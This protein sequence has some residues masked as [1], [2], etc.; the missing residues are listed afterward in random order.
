VSKLI[1]Q[2]V[3]LILP[4]RL[5]RVALTRIFGF[6]LD[7]TCRI[8]ISLVLPGHLVM[9]PHSRIGSLTMIKGLDHVQIDAW[10]FLGNLNWVTGLPATDRTFFVE[11]VGRRPSLHI[12]EHAAI[13]HRHMIDCNDRVEIGAFATF[14][15]WGSQILTHSIDIASSRQ[16]AESVRVGR[17]CFIGTRSILLKG[18]RLPDYSVLSAGSVLLRAEIEPYGL[19]AGNPAIRI[20]ELDPSAAYFT[21]PAGV[22]N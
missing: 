9:G 16:Q 2:L 14:G 17:Y 5:R 4:W 21:R 18:S 20:R 13:T 7:R 10:G 3:L 15:G 22:V 1:L 8:G 12:E 11:D 6:E 19:Y